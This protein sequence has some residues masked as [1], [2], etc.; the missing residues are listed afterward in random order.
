MGSNYD[1]PMIYL[2]RKEL[3]GGES[4]SINLEELENQ[5]WLF[6]GKSGSGKSHTVR[7]V[8]DQMSGYQ[9]DPRNGGLPPTFHVIGYHPDFGYDH[10]VNSGACRNIVPESINRLDFDYMEGDTSINP[11]QPLTDDPSAQFATIE[12]FIAYCK[13]V[14]PGIGSVQIKY[15]RD[16]LD[17][18]YSRCSKEGR[19]PDVT[20]L[21]NEIQMIKKSLK[22]G[23]GV[24]ATRA[25]QKLR[26]EQIEKEKAYK[27]GDADTKGK[28]KLEG[29]LNDLVAEMVDEFATYIKQN[30]IWVKDEYYADFDVGT[31]S[32]LDVLVAGLIRPNFF[33]RGCRTRPVQGLINVYDVHKLGERHQEL[34]TH[35]L[36]TRLYKRCIVTTPSNML[37]PA[38]AHTYIVADEVRYMNACARDL[39]SP[40][41]LI[42]GG[43]RKFGMGMLVGGQGA[44]QLSA[45][46]ARAFSV[47]I[48]LDQNEAA[49]N[50]TK[51]FFR[52][53]EAILRKIVSKRSAYVKSGSMS[54]LVNLFV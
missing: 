8:M 13:V 50:D 26:K 15:I 6:L 44:D 41:N 32:T 20:D 18:V 33:T 43:S 39:M 23:L 19:C 4:I 11:L 3:G 12:D 25:M 52:I 46:M 49:Y 34:M 47:K 40:A 37:N 5:F 17:N 48:I 16:I 21:F 14:H 28:E 31:V 36:L 42:M 54:E 38:V 22:S 27:S 45:D 2:G 35:V 7:H 29:E 1:S 10:F 53:N 24:E 51:K 9:L 30:T